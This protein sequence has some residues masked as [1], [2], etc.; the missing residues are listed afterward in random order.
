MKITGYQTYI[1]PPRWGFIK[2][3]TDVGIDGWGEPCLEGRTH[4]VHAC[5][6]EL[7]EYLVGKDPR[8]IE[9]HWNY[10]HRSSF[11]RGGPI[12]MSALAGIDQALW[13][14][15]GKALDAPVYQL[16]GGKCRDKI[17]T[18]SWIGGD[19]PD[20][21]VRMAQERKALGFNAVKMNGTE[22]L[23]F[24][25]EFS[26]VDALLDRV[27][28]VRDAMG[29]DFGIGVDFHGRVHKAMAKVLMK[30]LEPMHLMFVEEPVLA[31]H[32]ES[33]HEIA[34]YGAIPI[35]TGERMYSRWEFKTLLE[36]G[37]VDII[38]PDVCHCG[39]ITELKKIASMAEAYD[40][41]LAPHCPLG[42]I[43]LASSVHVDTTCQNAIIQEQSIGI[44]YNKGSDVLDYITNKEVFAFDQGYCHN[45]EG[46]GLGINID[47][48]F[49]QSQHE[50][51]KTQ[52]KWRNP[53]WTNEDGSF[54]EW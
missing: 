33:I 48:A 18:Y 24:I 3:T 19:R 12:M 49:M 10:M 45:I 26:K 31:E 20:D 29:K 14:I 34:K 52:A 32:F 9:L 8:D 36:R 16:L 44:H 28:S 54:A 30:E 46:P 37:G 42:P 43:A 27:Q 51:A 40:V 17:Q 23:N 5:V 6:D 15:K 47:E 50:L 22:E 39:G 13:D 53:Y 35:A 11:Y 7:M 38:Q 41:A 1:V 2:I 4:T 21:V 25:D